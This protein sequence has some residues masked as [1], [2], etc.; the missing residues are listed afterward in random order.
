MNS[1]EKRTF[2]VTVLIAPRARLDSS[3]RR[4]LVKEK[5]KSVPRVRSARSAQ[6]IESSEP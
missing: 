5:D 4:A 3:A 6:S 1:K 2:F